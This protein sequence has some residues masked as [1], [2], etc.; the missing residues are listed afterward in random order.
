M[1]RLQT[2]L[3]PG[4]AQLCQGPMYV[5]QRLTAEQILLA[6]TRLACTYDSS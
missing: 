5:L 1:Y 6:E 2:N 4:G 3:P